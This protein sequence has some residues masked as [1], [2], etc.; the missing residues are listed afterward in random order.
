MAPKLGGTALGTRHDM[1]ME[2]ESVR[3]ALERHARRNPHKTALYSLDQGK[4]ISFG[5]IH[6]LA[7]RVARR[8]AEQGI[9]K[10]DRVAILSDE[11]LEKLI[12]WMGIWRLGAVVCPLNIDQIS[13]NGVTF[14]FMSATHVDLLVVRFSP[15]TQHHFGT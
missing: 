10:G 3:S 4:S 7:N 14:F 12:L 9:G 13:V 2:F 8:L 6:H 5:E 11:C 15:P 1:A